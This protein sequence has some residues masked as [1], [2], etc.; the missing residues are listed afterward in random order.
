MINIIDSL[1][2]RAESTGQD[3]LNDL[4]D[5]LTTKWPS[6][7]VVYDT[8]TPS[9]VYQIWLSED[10]YIELASS[11]AFYYKHATFGFTTDFNHMYNAGR[12]KI[13]ETDNAVMIHARTQ[14]DWNYC[15]VIAET[16]NL[17]DGTSSYGAAVMTN[18][19]RI[20]AYTDGM[21]STGETQISGN[22]ATTPQYNEQF[23]PL[24]AWNTKDIFEHAYWVTARKSTTR[25]SILQNGTDYFYVVGMLAV[26]YE[27]G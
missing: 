16:Q 8:N 2:S 26:K 19:D 7:T 22:F 12:Y 21:Y 18:T 9:N 5:V 11:L 1:D 15:A 27:V 6:I 20:I 25:G 23:V 13:I 17:T 4:A 3:L 24:V 10:V 14:G